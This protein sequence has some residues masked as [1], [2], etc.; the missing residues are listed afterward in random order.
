[1]LRAVDGLVEV[2]VG[3]STWLL[4]PFTARGFADELLREAARAD[5]QR[6]TGRRRAVDLPAPRR[7]ASEKSEEEVPPC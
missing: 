3:E 1:M 2:R 6:L 4:Q 5:G 7:V